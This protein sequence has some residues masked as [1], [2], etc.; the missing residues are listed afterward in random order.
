MAWLYA[1]SLRLP[2]SGP[3]ASD[4]VPLDGGPALKLM[5]IG[6]QETMTHTDDATRS[7]TIKET[8]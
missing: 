5:P 2:P 7:A 8:D 1:I 3:P 6:M 4:G